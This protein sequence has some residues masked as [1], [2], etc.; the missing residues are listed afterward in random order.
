MQLQRAMRDKKMAVG[1][2]SDNLGTIFFTTIEG[3]PIPAGTYQVKRMPASANPRHGECF[4]VLNV[5]G[6]SDILFHA[7]NTQH[8]STGCILLGYGF[9][10]F[11][12]QP[13]ISQSQDALQRF[14]LFTAKLDGFMLVV[15][16]PS[17]GP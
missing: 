2:L 7:G 9:S 1:I 17:R 12:E 14:K 6:R 15:K 4:E 5:P 3:N 11:R 10:R 13:A 16:D 8:D